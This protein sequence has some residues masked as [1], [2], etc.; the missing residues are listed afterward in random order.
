MSYK[1]LMGY[2]TFP[3]KEVAESICRLL[4]TDQIIACANIFPPHTAIYAWQGKIQTESETAV[5][6][7]LNARKRSALKERI[8]AT[9]PYSVPALVFWSIEDGLPEFV[10]WVY[11][12]SL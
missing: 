11:G 12:Q 8:R 7:K 4:V 10:N 2:C 5:I 9:H 6:M 1:V 3:T